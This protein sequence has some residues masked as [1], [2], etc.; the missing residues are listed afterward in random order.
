MSYRENE[1]VV[2]H[3]GHPSK[4]CVLE[5]LV[6]DPHEVL[7]PVPAGREERHQHWHVGRRLVVRHEQEPLV[8]ELVQ[9]NSALADS[10]TIKT[11]LRLSVIFIYRLS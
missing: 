9:S 8:L 1:E 4:V 7:A 5:D 11:S 3:P 6:H 2:V 10:E